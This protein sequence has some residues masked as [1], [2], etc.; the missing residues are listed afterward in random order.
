MTGTTSETGSPA[1]EPRRHHYVPRCWLAGFTE[2]GENDDRLWVT[3]LSRGHQWPSTPDGAGHIRDFYRLEDENA[4][5]PVMAETALSRIETEVG[6][7]LRAV[8]RERRSPGV[9]EL[10]AILY[11][12]LCNGRGFQ[13]FGHSY[14]ECW[15]S[16]LMNRSAKNWKA[17]RPGGV[18]W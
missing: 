3:D 6:P 4:S 8:N 18:P 1:N 7:I 15:T 5:D 9:E 12:W 17:L 14:L 2:T 13:P 16:F 10:D 11:S